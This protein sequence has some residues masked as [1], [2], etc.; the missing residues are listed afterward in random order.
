MK[1]RTDFVTNSSSANFT[2]ELSF[3]SETGKKADFDLS[4]S[5]ET[6]FSNDGDM[7]AD[8]I[9]LTPELVDGEVCFDGAPAFQAQSI[10][11]LGTMIF[12]A[13]QIEGWHGEMKDPEGDVL[14]DLLS[15]H[16][17]SKKEAN[18][19]SFFFGKTFAIDDAIDY[20]YI[21]DA[22]HLAERIEA[23]GG[24]L[25]RTPSPDGDYIICSDGEDAGSEDTR[26]DVPCVGEFEILAR[27]A[28]EEGVFDDEEE[29]EDDWEDDDDWDEDEDDDY[30][31]VSVRNVAPKTIF[32]FLDACRKNGITPDNLKTVIVKNSKFG[33]GDSAM[34]VECDELLSAFESYYEE[35]GEDRNPDKLQAL[36]D[37]VKSV[38]MLPVNDNEYSLPDEMPCAW[39]QSDNKLIKAMQK[40][41]DGELSADHWMGTL[42]NEYRIDVKKKTIENREVLYFGSL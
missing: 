22:D 9:S 37:Y 16:N 31:A 4:V 40:L 18:E 1:I 33:S 41:L 7:T 14:R 11:E 3:V 23:C 25:I 21:E 29:D 38:P 6:C 28:E 34:W 30:I 39:A 2:L 42:T 36:V 5:P 26:G 8:C 20:A 13:A 32:R 35:Q 15:R 12:E 27:L 10:E 17:P 19:E 24:K